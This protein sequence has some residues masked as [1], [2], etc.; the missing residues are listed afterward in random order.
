MFVYVCR[1]GGTPLI[2]ISHDK[3]GFLP[4]S[5]CTSDALTYAVHLRAS[6]VSNVPN[7]INT[8]N[9]TCFVVAPPNP[10]PSVNVVIA[11]PAIV[12]ACPV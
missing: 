7:G 1:A 9:E 2:G 8:A 4:L 10:L 5:N 11:A 12:G 6:V 3:T